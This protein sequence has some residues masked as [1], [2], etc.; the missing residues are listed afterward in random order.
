[1]GVFYILL[2]IPLILQHIVIKGNHLDYQKRN[3][4]ALTFFFSFLTGLV[5]LR[6]ESVGNDT[7]NYLFYFRAYSNLPWD[8]LIDNLG[9][10]KESLFPILNKAISVISKEPQFYIAVTAV[11]ICALIYPTYRR[12]CTDA[13]LTVVLFSIMSTFVMMFS[14]IRQMLAIGIGFFAYDLTRQKK[15]LPF[16][17]AV[18]VAMCLHT[19]A[20][21]LVFMYPLY[22]ARVTKKWLYVVVPVLLLV[23][24]FN[25]QIFTMLGLILERYTEFSG[26]IEPTGAY[27][28]I[29]LFALF[30][31]F[32][33]LIPDEKMLDEETIGLRN[34]LLLALAVQL[35]APLNTLA[36]RMGY[37]YIIFIPLLI[38]RI[39][40]CRSKRWNQ[41]ALFA[42]HIMLIVF[43]LYFFVSAYG[44]GGLHVFPYHFFWENV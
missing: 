16:V 31:V 18:V 42:R 4:I 34:F 22:H 11:I 23:F 8:L 19:S 41:I 13:S 24:V 40:V 30:V 27:T 37:Y 28:M 12:L 33:Y 44:G 10:T 21:M 1:M 9:R 35:F 26:A 25:E 29:V 32:S 36:M 15:L 3:R 43:T 5:M 17:V 7:S 20:F 39:V 14:G 38:P 6:H 2:S